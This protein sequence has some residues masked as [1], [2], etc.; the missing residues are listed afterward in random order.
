MPKPTPIQDL[1]KALEN[2]DWDLFNARIVWSLNSPRCLCKPCYNN[3][4]QWGKRLYEKQ[5]DGYQRRIDE[6]IIHRRNVQISRGLREREI[7]YLTG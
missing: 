5:E 7:G 2:I 4:L 3:W 1:Q 6:E